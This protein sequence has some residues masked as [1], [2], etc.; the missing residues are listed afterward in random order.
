MVERKILEEWV[1]STINNPDR[2]ETG[3]DNTVHYFK[4]I[5][6][7]EGHTLHAVVN[8]HVSPK[9]IVTIF[10]DRRARRKK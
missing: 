7:H 4:V 2:E 9:K 3:A 6:E 1:W 8:P 5:P 10:F